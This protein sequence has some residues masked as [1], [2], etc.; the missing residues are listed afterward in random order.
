MPNADVVFDA[1]PAGRWRNSEHGAAQCGGSPWRRARY[2]PFAGRIGPS[3]RDEGHH[4]HRREHRAKMPRG[5]GATGISKCS[6]RG[7][8]SERWV[9]EAE[10]GRLFEGVRQLQHTQVVAISADH[11]KADRQASG[12]ETRGDGNRRPAGR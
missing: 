7:A 2:V 12:G 6:C 4:A 11:L 8:K 9:S 10:S 1:R 5:D 3:L